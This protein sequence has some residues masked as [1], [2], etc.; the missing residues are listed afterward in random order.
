MMQVYDE[1]AQPIE[2][3]PLNLGEEILSADE[4]NAKAARARKL[5]AAAP[6]MLEALKFIANREN[7]TFAECSDAE[8]II[9]TAK[10]AIRVAE[11]Q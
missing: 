8:E 3:F 1:S 7:M 6:K 10:E 11:G 4:L 5:W 2:Q 9:A